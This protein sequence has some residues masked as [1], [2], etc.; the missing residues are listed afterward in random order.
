[1]QGEIPP[2]TAGFGEAAP[3]RGQGRLLQEGDIVEGMHDQAVGHLPR[4]LGHHGAQ[5]AQQHRG[6]AEVVGAGVEHGCHQG[7]P[8]VL[9]VKIQ[10]GAVLPA[11]EDGLERLDV[12]AHTRRR[13][14]EVGTEALLDVGPDLG[15]YAQQEMPLA[16]TLQVPGLVGQVHGIA[17]KGH[18]D[19]GG[20]IHPRRVLTGQHQRQEG[21]RAAL[22][23]IDAV[24]TDGGQA[25]GLG[26]CI[27]ETGVEWAVYFHGFLPGNVRPSRRTLT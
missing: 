17:R 18:G 6:D 2:F 19:A 22:Q 5:G 15:A 9:A 8:I 12:F 16:E 10:L 7:V 1:M 20:D 27:I 24:V 13:A 25:G 14:L 3:Y 21:I 23:G 26:S 11:G 4:H